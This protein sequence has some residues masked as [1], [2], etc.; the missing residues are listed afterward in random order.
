MKDLHFHTL[1]DYKTESGFRLEKI[2]LSYQ[3]FGQE[4][5]SAPIVL[6][7]HALT[8]NSDL[9]SPEKGWW[10]E[11]VEDGKLIDTR[12]YTVIAFNIP[13]NGYDENL[14]EDYQQFSAKD[15]AKLF[16]LSLQAL[17]IDYLYAAIGGSIG[18]GIAWEMAA[19]YP[20]YIKYLIP[21]A[22]HWKSSDWIIGH[23]AIQESI[24]LNSKKPLQDA[25]KMA[26]LFYRTPASLTKKFNRTKTEDQS[27]FNVVSWLNHHGE[28]LE[29]RFTIKAYLLMNHLLTSLNISGDSASV[30]EV[31]QPIESEIIQIAVDSDLFF[32]KEET[33]KTKVLLDKL[34]V[35]NQYFEIKS[36]DGHDAF[37]IENEQITQFLNPRFKK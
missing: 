20:K 3:F 30:E 8:G 37:L 25:R 33:I 9:N 35:K 5:H 2:K 21:I 31:L 32:V 34:K 4:L 18:G 1:Y 28:K 10:K 29:S 36:V 22:A 13:G 12:K 17:K 27:Q 11:I 24:L 19:L 15:I 26:M 7:N 14:I 6:V 16:Y 23:N